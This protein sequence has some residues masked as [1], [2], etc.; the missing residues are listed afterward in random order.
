VNREDTRRLLDVVEVIRSPCDLD[1]LL[2]FVRHPRSLLTSDQIAALLGYPIKDIA[3][4]LEGLLAADLL[5]GR[6]H[7]S[8]A[9][10][11]Y[12]FAASGQPNE[13]LPAVLRLA[14]TR[15]GRLSFVK[16]L[17]APARQGTSQPVV[18]QMQSNHTVPSVGNAE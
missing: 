7:P 12:I 8:Q 18:Q 15:A 2:F 6:Q 3:V 9:A 4:S 11:M 16:A 14:S 10:S 13:G 17:G 5:S 1:L